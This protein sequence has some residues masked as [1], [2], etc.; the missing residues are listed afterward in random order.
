[1][2]HLFLQVIAPFMVVGYINGKLPSSLLRPI[3]GN[4]RMRKDA[5]AAY[6][7]MYL[8]AKRRGVDMRIIEGSLR[9]TYREYAAQLVAWSIYLHGGN[10]AARPGTSNH[11][12]ALAVDLMS[13]VQ[14]RMV[15]LI[16]RA[17]GFSKAWSDAPGEWWHIKW[18]EGHYA[19][20]K[21]YPRTIRHNSHGATVG[22]LNY[23]LRGRGFKKIP[24]HGKP[25][26]DFFGRHTVA[27]VKHFQKNHHLKSDGVV[28]PSTWRALGVH[29]K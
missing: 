13:M 19:D 24:A 15:D 14:R 27:A 18:R 5:A 2:I 11:G 12:W 1:M 23:I 16:G 22:R 28:G 9:R 26:H 3:P 20:V 6:T 10:L 17:F 4:G 7:A 29:P 25:G 21:S 8:L